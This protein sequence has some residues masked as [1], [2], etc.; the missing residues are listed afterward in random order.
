VVD[1]ALIARIRTSLPELPAARRRRYE[2]AYQ[3]SAYDATVLTQHHALGVLFEGALRAGAGAKPAANWI[4]GDYLAY[5][6]ARSLE[7]DA[8]KL[9]PEWLAHLLQLMDEG[10]ISGKMAKELFVQVLERGEDPRHLVEQGGLRQLSDAS[11]LEPIADEVLRANQQTVGDY[12]KGKTTAF[13]H[14]MGQAMKLSKGKANPQQ[15]AALLKRKLE[16]VP[17]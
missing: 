11:E 1:P 16:Q 17:S 13:T 15:M 4:M 7:P 2:A 14:L 6:N 12:L 9:R 10:T 8:S 3:L 5:L